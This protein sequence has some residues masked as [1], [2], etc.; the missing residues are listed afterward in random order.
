MTWKG[1]LWALVTLGVLA[2]AIGA[3]WVEGILPN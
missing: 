3:S 1:V 2:I